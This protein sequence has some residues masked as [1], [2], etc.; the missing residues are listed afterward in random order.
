MKVKIEGLC[1]DI[2]PMTIDN[3]FGNDIA[4]I[5]KNL[6]PNE[7]VTLKIVE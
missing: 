1:F 7:Q 4:I 2:P 6:R 5:L 3:K